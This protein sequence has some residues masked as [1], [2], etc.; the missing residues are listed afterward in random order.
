MRS[1]LT[2]VPFVLPRSSTYQARPRKVRV[3]CSVEA[4]SS[5]TTIELFTSRP[6]V[7]TASRPNTVPGCGP[8]IPE[9]QPGDPEHEQVQAAEEG[10]PDDP[11]RDDIRIHQPGETAS[12]TKTVVPTSIRSPAPR[13]TSVTATPLT[14][15][16]L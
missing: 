7:A 14:C 11:D 6:I 13:A 8:K 16:P 2:N 3:A 15:E 4:N 10:N 12:I 5:S 9:Q 1:P